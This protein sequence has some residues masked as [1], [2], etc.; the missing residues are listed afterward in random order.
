MHTG[1]CNS[2]DHCTNVGKEGHAEKLLGELNAIR[3]SLANT[4]NN[5]G[6]KNYTVPDILHL[7][8]PACIGI[9]EYALS[10][11]HLI[12]DDGVHLNEDGLRCLANA[13]SRLIETPH[14]Q[15]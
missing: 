7:M 6:I 13:L 5:L 2:S 15:I 10:L 4:L 11:K 1:C 9:A 14:W 3:I 12:K 8:M